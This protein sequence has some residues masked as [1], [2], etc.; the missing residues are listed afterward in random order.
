M[1]RPRLL[2][3]SAA[4]F[5]LKAADSLPE[6]LDPALLLILDTIVSL[7]EQ[8]KDYDR[9]VEGWFNPP[10]HSLSGRTQARSGRQPVA[11]SLP[12]SGA[13]VPTG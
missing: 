4:S 10:R 2:C 3:C 1:R 12:I 9:H 11:F 7:T 5:H 13:E 8:I 6:R